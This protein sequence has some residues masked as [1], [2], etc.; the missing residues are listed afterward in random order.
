MVARLQNLVASGAVADLHALSYAVA[1]LL[2]VLVAASTVPFALIQVWVNDRTIKAT[3]Q[4]LITDRITAAVTGLGAEKTV[5]KKP[6]E[7]AA[8]DAPAIEYT[9]HTEPNLEVRLGA[10]YVLERIA[11]DSDRDHIQIMKIL[12]GYIRNNAPWTPAQSAEKAKA[13]EKRI[14]FKEPRA[15]IQAALTVIGRRAR[16]KIAQEREKEFLLDL[17]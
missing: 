14:I 17:R 10:G 15:D 5:K 12:C 4:G 16:D 1:V 9:D 6:V 7:T 2:G 3:E 8:K 11:Q 13:P